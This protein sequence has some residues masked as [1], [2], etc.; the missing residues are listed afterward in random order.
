MRTRAKHPQAHLWLSRH[1]LEAVCEA[2][3]RLPRAAAAGPTT[4]KATRAHLSC[5]R[6]QIKDGSSDRH[7]LHTELPPGTPPPKRLRNKARPRA[8]TAEQHPR[9]DELVGKSLVPE[10]P[11]TTQTRAQARKASAG[12]PRT[13]ATR[14]RCDVRGRCA[15]AAWLERGLRRRETPKQCG[16]LHCAFE[17]VDKG[18]DSWRDYGIEV[19]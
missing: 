11:T 19:T 17:L 10:L 18:L 5:V 13:R 16:A 7:R 6:C 9:R 4:R 1:A 14:D 15:V 3:A 12:E 8:A 2:T